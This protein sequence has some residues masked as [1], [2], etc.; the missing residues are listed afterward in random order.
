MEGIALMELVRLY[1]TIF[2]IAIALALIG[3]LKSCTL[4]LLGLT[5]ERTG[6]GMISFTKYTKAL[7]S[8]RSRKP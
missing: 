5:A 4:E 2:K 1:L 3:Q 7:T 8:D 6:Q